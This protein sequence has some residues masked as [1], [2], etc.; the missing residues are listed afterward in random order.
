MGSRMAMNLLNDGHRLVVHDRSITAM[1][2]LCK[3]AHAAAFCCCL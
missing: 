3:A 2:Q 1:E